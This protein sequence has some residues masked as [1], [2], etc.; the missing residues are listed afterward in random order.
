MAKRLDLYQALEVRQTVA[1][2][3]ITIFGWCLFHRSILALLSATW[4]RQLTHSVAVL[5]PFF[6]R[7][8]PIGKAASED[9]GAFERKEIRLRFS[10]GMA[11]TSVALRVYKKTDFLED[12][13]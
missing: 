11:V 5:D 3:A 6:R 4:V 1:F 7:K 8:G 10:A 2:F 12:I 9:A 13:V